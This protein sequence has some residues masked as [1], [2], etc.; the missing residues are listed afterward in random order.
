[1]LTAMPAKN[2]TDPILDSARLAIH[3]EARAVEFFEECRWGA[4]PACARCGSVS[5]Y[6][7]TKEDGTRNDD[8]RWRCRDCNTMYTVRTGMV[9]EESRLPLRVWAF[10]FW[11]GCAS[12]KGVS[13]LQMSRECEISYK[14]ALR[15]MHSVRAAMAELDAPPLGGPGKTIEADE[16]YCGGKPRRWTGPHKRGRGTSK[17]PVIGIVERGGNVRFRVMERVTSSGLAAAIAENAD[18]R[19]RLITDE[20][21]AYT[22]LGRD[23][24]GGHQTVHHTRGEYVRGDVHSNTVEGVFSLLKRGLYGTFHSVSKDYLGR[25]LAEFEFRHNHRGEGDGPRTVH[26]IRAAMGKR[27]PYSTRTA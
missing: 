3:D 14:S 27:C 22:I 17:T 10:A 25:Y 1:M 2:P 24:E 5:V 7:M 15:V 26:A 4:N 21:N 23:F 20:S 12:K 16:T 18:L 9:F 8:F 13:A 19:S 11:K 6:Q